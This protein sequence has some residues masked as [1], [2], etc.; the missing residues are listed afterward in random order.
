MSNNNNGNNRVVGQC[1]D[2]E[3]I[4]PGD[5]RGAQ[6]LLGGEFG[7]GRNAF[8]HSFEHFQT[9]FKEVS[10]LRNR[11]NYNV[12]MYPQE[13]VPHSQTARRALMLWLY[14][15][16]ALNEKWGEYRLPPDLN[17]AKE[18]II[19]VLNPNTDDVA[20]EDGTANRDATQ[21][22]AVNGGNAN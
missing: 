10:E 22:N 4:E 6:L 9:Y 5:F 13:I 1:P 19:N 20:A 14:D 11:M 17:E 18:S 21:R 7:P 2:L 3:N 16:E 12:H 15:I 8:F